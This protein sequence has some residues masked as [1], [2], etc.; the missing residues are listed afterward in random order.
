MH[1]KAC[2]EEFRERKDPVTGTYAELC[3]TC[4]RVSRDEASAAARA[5]EADPFEDVV[6]GSARETMEWNRI[7]LGHDFGKGLGLMDEDQRLNHL[8]QRAAERFWNARE[9]GQTFLA[10]VEHALGYRRFRGDQ[11]DVVAS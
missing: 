6:R 7:L 1:C 5:A 3:P 2:N 9:A 4:N 10:S 8:R 11:R